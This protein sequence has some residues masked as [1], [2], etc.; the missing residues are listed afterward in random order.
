MAESHARERISYH[1]HA[2]WAAYAACGWALLFAVLSF[3]WVA[4]G[5]TGFHPLEQE[6]TSNGSVWIVANVAAGVL[7]VVA[8]LMALALVYL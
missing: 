3:F 6:A 5:R 2:R 1:F 4:G 8:G 7:K